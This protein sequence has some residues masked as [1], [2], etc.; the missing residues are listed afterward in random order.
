MK[1][2]ERERKE[3]GE[4][5]REREF[6]QTNKKKTKNKKKKHTLTEHLAHSDLSPLRKFISPIAHH[7]KKN[8][9]LGNGGSAFLYSQFSALR[10]G[11]TEAG[12]LL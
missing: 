5:E 1:E 3:R 11:E 2:R 10:S 7:W 4:R 9:H 8:I 6:P 12:R